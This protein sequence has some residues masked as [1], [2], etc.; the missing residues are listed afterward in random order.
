MAQDVYK[1]IGQQGIHYS[2]EVKGYHA[3]LCKSSSGKQ[4]PMAVNYERHIVLRKENITTLAQTM[5][6]ILTRMITL[7]H[8]FEI[9]GYIDGGSG[10]IMWLYVTRSNNQPKNVTALKHMT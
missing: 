7:R 10:K 8:G 4:I 2:S 6:G 3:S 9:H 1:D 5:L